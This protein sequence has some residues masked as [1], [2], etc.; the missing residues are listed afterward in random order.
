MTKSIPATTKALEQ[1]QA[2]VVKAT[3]GDVDAG[4]R[5]TAQ[6]KRKKKAPAP[7]SVTAEMMPII[8]LT[9]EDEGEGFILM[10]GTNS[11]DEVGK[12]VARRGKRKP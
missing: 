1:R 2:P 9:A 10:P 8:E 12:E 11:S 6:A 3:A 4:S 5:M 7:V